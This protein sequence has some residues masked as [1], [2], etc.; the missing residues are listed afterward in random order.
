MMPFDRICIVLMIISASMLAWLDSSSAI[1]QQQQQIET[2]TA[3]VLMLENTQA[4]I[5][6]IK[7]GEKK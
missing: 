4:E 5:I 2:L 3:R 6:G 1:E 7:P